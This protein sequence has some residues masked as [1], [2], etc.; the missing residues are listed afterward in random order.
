[1]GCD[2]SIFKCNI[3]EKK[4][5]IEVHEKFLIK[6]LDHKKKNC[7]HCQKLTAGMRYCSEK[8]ILIKKIIKIPIL[9]KIESSNLMEKR[10][11][12]S[13]KT[14]CSENSFFSEN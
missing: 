12:L 14:A 1:M 7:Y 3:L 10:L 13:I 5:F 4:N 2:L 11:S 6:N 9:K 8:Y